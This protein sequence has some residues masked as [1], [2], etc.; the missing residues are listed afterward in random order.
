[1]GCCI[2]SQF[3][4][5]F[6]FGRQGVEKIHFRKCNFGT[7]D[8]LTTESCREKPGSNPD[9]SSH[10][11]RAAKM[12]EYQT[13]C[14]HVLQWFVISV[15]MVRTSKKIHFGKLDFSHPRLKLQVPGSKPQ[16]P[17]GVAAQ[18]LGHSKERRQ[19]AKVASSS[20]VAHVP[21][22]PF[23][24]KMGCIR[25][26]K[27]KPPRPPKKRHEWQLIQGRSLERAK[28]P[29]QG[30]KRQPPSKWCPLAPL[31]KVVKECNMLPFSPVPERADP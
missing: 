17:H 30:G 28:M 8:Y 23:C 15:L 22:A 12:H 3:L 13:G 1:M 9:V 31:A 24:C 14:K 29:S 4:F 11:I 2:A 26:P 21:L 19:H 25:A 20:S 10:L 27:A 16:A 6:F 18:R 7:C 5:E